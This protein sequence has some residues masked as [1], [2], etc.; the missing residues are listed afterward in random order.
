MLSRRLGGFLAAALC[1]AGVQAEAQAAQACR[2]DLVMD[3]FSKWND[4]LNSLGD[5][6]SGKAWLLLSAGQRRVGEG[7]K[8]C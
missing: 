6:T 1:A 4:A 7:F 8:G 5:A 2:S 3:N